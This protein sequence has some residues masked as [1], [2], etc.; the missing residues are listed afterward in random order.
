L[1]ELERATLLDL[2]RILGYPNDFVPVRPRRMSPGEPP[3]EPDPDG[4]RWDQAPITVVDKRA[5]NDML[6][7]QYLN[8]LIDRVRFR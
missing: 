5:L 7:Q 3:S 8:E 1:D 6:A 4:R 2:V